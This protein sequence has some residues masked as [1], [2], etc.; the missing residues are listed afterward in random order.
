[1]KIR[2]YCIILLG[3]KPI[4]RPG[5]TPMGRRELSVLYPDDDSSSMTAIER[6]IAKEKPGSGS[7]KRQSEKIPIAAHLEGSIS[8]NRGHFRERL[9]L[10]YPV[11]S[12]ESSQV[13][14]ELFSL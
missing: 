9:P 14:P 5:T 3:H 10:I 6:R 11:E 4:H 2:I 12:R 7:R 13:A 8:L 1:M